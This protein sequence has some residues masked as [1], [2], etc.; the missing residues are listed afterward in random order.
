MNRYLK[1]PSSAPSV[2]ALCCIG[3]AKWGIAPARDLTTADPAPSTGMN[4]GLEEIVIS[5]DRRSTDI[6][7]TALTISVMQAPALQ[8]DS[9][10]HLSDVNGRVPGLE[11]TETSGYE[12]AVAIRGV[13]LGAPENELTASPGVAMFIDGVYIANSISLDETLFDLDHLEVLRGPPGTL[14]GQSS[15]GGA[16][17]LVT[18]QPRL[19]EFNS[20]GAINL[21]SYNLH[22]EQG[23]LNVPIGDRLAIRVSAQNYAHD[24]FTRDALLPNND[25]DDAN[26]FSGKSA[27]LYM[28]TDDFSV[29]LTTQFY[30]SHRHGE[31]QKNI[32]DPSPDPYVV[33]QDYPSRFVLETSLTHLNLEWLLPWF[34]VKSVTAYQ[35]LDHQQQEDGSRSAFSLIGA[36]DDVSGWNTNLHNYNEE[37]DILSNGNTRLDWITGVF[38][39]HQTTRQIVTEFECPNASQL[40]CTAPTLAQI[41]ITPTIESLPPPNLVFGQDLRVAHHSYAWFA[42]GTYHI[43][44]GLRMTGGVRING[45]GYQA[46]TLAFGATTLPSS[47]WGVIPTW[48]AA[49][50]YDLSPS[51][52]IYV[53]T[54]RGYKP[55]G[56][57]TTNTQSGGAVLTTPRFSPETNTSFEA[58]SKNQ[59]LRNSLRSNVAVFYY[60]YRDMQY[61]AT[62]PKEFAGGIEN[63]PS[64]RVW[65][66]EAE[67]SYTGLGHQLRANG[68]LSLESG[69]VVG[70]YYAIDSTI[71]QHLAATLPVCMYGGTFYSPDCFKAEEAAAANISGST[72]PQMPEALASFDISYDVPVSRGVLTPRIE[73]IYRGMFWQR[74]FNQTGVD[75][76]PAYSLVNLNIEYFPRESKRLSVQLSLTN[77]FNKA[78]VNSRY[79]DPYGTFTTSQQFIPPRQITGTVYYSFGGP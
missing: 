11:I 49:V 43:L 65:G 19:G 35:Y 30:R 10:D 38:A 62:D 58:G 68:T 21:G 73:Y 22:R 28:P 8:A 54:A 57:N 24:G 51:N 1:V 63:I 14:Y 17:L 52:L 55:G 42:Q 74:I 59:L 16:I 9:I 45:D 41:A 47:Y 69:K 12:T 15:I 61:I 5:A 25:L 76:V 46:S 60:V 64:T 79:T 48:R 72:P 40:T 78:G 26:D 37:F 70:S 44:D 71:Q 7:K 66:G 77:L 4:Q 53:S 13:G 36:Y 34:T 6:Q 20:A 31:A 2:L 33:N 32:G 39:L 56:I 27:F 75:S 23:E 18:K 29:T 50:E 67:L 3:I